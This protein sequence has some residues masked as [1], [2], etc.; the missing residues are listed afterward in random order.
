MRGEPADR[1]AM[2]TAPILRVLAIVDEDLRERLDQF[3]E[4]TKVVVV[5]LAVFVMEHGEERVV[6]IIAPLRV[7][8]VASGLARADDPRIVEVAFGD[9]DHS[10]VVLGAGDVDLSGELLHEV[11]GGTI[12]ELMHSIETEAIE[13]KVAEPHQRVVAEE[14]ADLVGASAFEVHGV[15]PR[16][17]VQRGEVRG[18][19]A[20]VVSDWP[21]VVVDDIEN[22]GETLGMTGVH[23][24]LECFG[25]TVVFRYR[26]ERHAVVAPATVAG[27]RRDRH[28]LDV[29][30]SQL[31]EV[32][33]ARDG[34][35][36]GAL[37]G[38]GSDMHLVDDG[39]G[40]R[41][42]LPTRV[43]PG[44]GMLIVDAREAMHTVRLP[45]AA[46]IGVGRG[47]VIEQEPVV[48]AGLRIGNLD[49]PPAAVVRAL[50]S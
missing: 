48:V 40:E 17:A 28:D 7:H 14:T 46:R 6:K 37:S 8:A 44:E 12:D 34:A 41:R 27:E 31:G 47:I 16:R 5:S 38:E 18:E 50:I 49:T 20:G 22:D 29:G 30:D 10:A 45:L 43:A 36:E 33:E 19:L 9:Q 15:A 23:K 26:E 24:A 13:V 3:F 39:T 25:A 42:S 21:E 1:T 2:V 11:H 35:V 4:G 32:A